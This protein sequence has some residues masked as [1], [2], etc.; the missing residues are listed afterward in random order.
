MTTTRLLRTTVLAAVLTLSATACSGDGGGSDDTGDTGGSGEGR[1]DALSSATD[2]AAFEA[3][4]C[5]EPPAVLEELVGPYEVLPPEQLTLGDPDSDE[6]QYVACGWTDQASGLTSFAVELYPS[7]PPTAFFTEA[8]PGETCTELSVAGYDHG[9]SCV[10]A[11]ATAPPLAK[12]EVLAVDG[13]QS[14]LCRLHAGFDRT[15]TPSVDLGEQVGTFTEACEE[16]LSS[17]GA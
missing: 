14:L 7:D 10:P 4:V 11:D 6:T 5:D 8:V 13:E 3:S 12:L 15:T 9:H 2:N 16:M 17:A 1:P